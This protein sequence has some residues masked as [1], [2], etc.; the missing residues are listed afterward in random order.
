VYR[1]PALQIFTKE[2]RVLTV[3]GYGVYSNAIRF[4][5]PLDSGLGPS[6]VRREAKEDD[7]LHPLFWRSI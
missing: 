4:K 1:L 3:S 6:G 5:A 7:K 2:Y